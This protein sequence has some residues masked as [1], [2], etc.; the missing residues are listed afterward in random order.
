MLGFSLKAWRGS[1]GRGLANGIGSLSA[2]ASP[3]ALGLLTGSL[4]R[5]LGGSGRSDFLGVSLCFASTG[6]F[7]AGGGTDFEAGLGTTLTGRGGI[8][9]ELLRTAVG[10]EVWVGDAAGDGLVGLLDWIVDGAGCDGFFGGETR[11]FRGS[12]RLALVG[13]AA[14]RSRREAAMGGR[15]SRGSAGARGISTAGLG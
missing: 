1:A 9:A 12:E 15:N 14:V 2:D 4:L 5:W 3:V 13:R 10:L 7:G 6:A 8:E 11:R